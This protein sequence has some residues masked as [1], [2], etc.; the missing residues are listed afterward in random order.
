MKILRL[1]HLVLTVEDL[2]TTVRFYEAVLGLEARAFDAGRTALH[3]G[4]QKINLHEVG[5]LIEPRAAQ[6]T[7]G[8]ADL[9]FVTDTPIAAVLERLADEGVTVEKGPVAQTGAEGPMTSV[10][11]RDP[12]GNLIEVANYDETPPR[13]PAQ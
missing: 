1:D 8:S 3:F 13:E 5:K 12:S 6:A 9:C 10:Y 7:V 4:D 2:D 11:F